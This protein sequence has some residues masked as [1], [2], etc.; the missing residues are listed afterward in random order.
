MGLVAR[1]HVSPGGSPRRSDNSCFAEV[2]RQIQLHIACKSSTYMANKRFVNADI[3][4]G[5][6][7]DNNCD[8]DN[9]CDLIL[10]FL[11]AFFFDCDKFFFLRLAHPVQRRT[12]LARFLKRHKLCLK[13]LWHNFRWFAG[14][15]F[16]LHVYN[17]FCLIIYCASLKFNVKLVL[18]L[19]LLLLYFCNNKK[20]VISY[21]LIRL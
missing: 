10:S 13:L 8:N 14:A 1:H 16:S 3:N 21:A 19:Q 5:I 6:A 20:I 18:R 15:S 2:C 7:D 9:V 12:F 17:F 4:A 11:S